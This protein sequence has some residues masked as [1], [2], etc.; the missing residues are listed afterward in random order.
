MNKLLLTTLLIGLSS[1]ALSAMNQPV[2]RV[3]LTEKASAVCSDHD[4]QIKHIYFTP[5]GSMVTIGLDKAVIYDQQFQKCSE[6]QWTHGAPKL[7]A[8]SDQYVAVAHTPKT[9]TVYTPDL[10]KVATFANETLS[11]T[12]LC[13]V[14]S[15]KLAAG[16]HDGT[17]VL[18][19]VIQ[20]LKKPI[21]LRQDVVCE[22]VDMHAHNGVLFI[23][24]SDGSSAQWDGINE[25]FYNKEQYPDVP[26]IK[27]FASCGKSIATVS[28]D[29]TVRVWHKESS[30]NNNFMPR[31]ISCSQYTHLVAGSSFGLVAV[32][33]NN[34]ISLYDAQSKELVQELTVDGKITHL[35]FAPETNKLI[36]GMMSGRVYVYDYEQFSSQKQ[37]LFQPIEITKEYQ[38]QQQLTDVL[39]KAHEIKDPNQRLALLCKTAQSAQFKELDRDL[40]DSDINKLHSAITQ[41]HLEIAL[42]KNG[43]DR[44]NA[45]QSLLRSNA[46]K[47]LSYADQADFYRLIQNELNKV[48]L[49]QSLWF[50]AVNKAIQTTKKTTSWISDKVTNALLKLTPILA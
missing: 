28:G 21:S 8:S 39:S 29:K 50:N 19:D 12:K 31:T 32:A 20:Q 15:D 33:H 13:F 11:F 26:T 22:I 40:F 24:W 47:A 2:T 38:Q 25:D 7:V 6:L 46:F 10:K 4:R 27:G 35:T 41:A 14:E 23:S 49:V 5:S 34:G 1:G 42:L 30:K 45:L 36:I 9:I 44:Y 48:W 17:V 16:L 43:R 18:I 3:S 37:E